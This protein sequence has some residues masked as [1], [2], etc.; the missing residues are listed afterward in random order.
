MLHL[1]LPCLNNVPINCNAAYRIDACV[2]D[3][4][5]NKLGRCC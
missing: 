3:R 1:A 2:C 4:K 5:S